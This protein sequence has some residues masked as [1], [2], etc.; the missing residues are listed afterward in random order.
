MCDIEQIMFHSFHQNFLWFLLFK[1]NDLSKWI[2]ENKMTVHLFSNGPSPAIATFGPR[3]KADDSDEKYGERNNRLCPQRLYVN[4]RLISCP[5]E[6]EAITLIRNAQ[7]MLATANLHLHKVVSNSVLI[8]EAS[9]RLCQEH[10]RSTPTPRFTTITTL[11]WGPL[12]PFHL[13]C[14]AARKAL[15]TQNSVYD[16]LGFVS[17]VIVERKLI[18]QQIVIM[19]KKVNG[20]DPLGWDDPL[21][22]KMKH[23]WSQWIDILA[24]LEEVLLPRCHHPKGIG[25]VTR[26]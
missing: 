21:L 22:E 4:D 14:L 11:S 12:G 8:M 6:N 10:Q 5:T 7:A 2:I 26:R 3:E 17:P 24:K 20:N 9:R 1:N 18:L 13:P 25:T 16:P 19:G 23:C 15:C